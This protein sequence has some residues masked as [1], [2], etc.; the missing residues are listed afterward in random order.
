[1]TSTEF[2]SLQIALGEARSE[3]VTTKRELEDMTQRAVAA[4]RL[5]EDA[6][7]HINSYIE[8]FK[9]AGLQAQ[10]LI[11]HLGKQIGEA[12]ALRNRLAKVTDAL[13]KAD[14]LVLALEAKSDTIEALRAEYAQSKLELQ[15]LDG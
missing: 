1:M 5:V 13:S 8:E 3:L 6:R 2:E 9:Q 10:I 14:A 4:E 15:T 12:D 7:K 11:E